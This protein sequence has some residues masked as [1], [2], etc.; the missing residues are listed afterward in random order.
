MFLNRLFGSLYMAYHRWGQERYSFKPLA[1]IEADR[2]R[3]ARRMAAYAYRYVPYY[4]ESMNRLG[5]RPDDFRTASDLSKLP[6]LERER[7]QRDPELLVSTERPL[8][9]YLSVRSSGSTGT[10]SSFFY[11]ARTVLQDAA[12]GERAR[13]VFTPL[14]G[15][16]LG[17]RITEIDMG[18]DSGGHVQQFVRENA[19]LPRG[20]DLQQQHLS[21]SD[22]LETNWRLINEFKPDVLQSFG[23]Y[24]AELFAYA[25]AAGRPF[26]RPKAIRYTCDRLPESA[27][28]LIEREFGIPVF[29]RYEAME[30][31][32][33]GFECEKH[34]GVHLNIDLCP[35]RI[36]DERGHDLPAG[37]SGEVIISNL[38]NRS[39][40]FL[41][42][43][44]GD[45]ATL[46]KEPCSCGRTLPLLSHVEGRRTDWLELPSGRRVHPQAMPAIFKYQQGI[47]QYQIV[48][49][50]S[51]RF[52]I[53]LVA[54]EAVDRSETS[55]RV[56]AELVSALGEEVQ[57]DVQFVPAIPRTPRG[58]V[59]TVI[60]FS[61]GQE[62][63]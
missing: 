41:N 38:I 45:M 57:V 49:E 37:E 11:D 34:N 25:R 59:R 62:R 48:Q 21:M 58:K 17:Y 20:V 35:V 39:T 30:A 28:Q 47:W 60:S 44:L 3:R 53:N 36:V 32:N 18:A 2:D 19:W 61:G 51:A 56:A 31:A 52:R 13:A 6:I 50:T 55:K 14:V 15:K 24:L 43:R 33:I 54:D 16:S 22:S 7:L 5:L 23:S 26:Y 40:V 63:S 42:Y 4:R 10:P 29:S 9:D 12:F 27:R 1:E 46:L 8:S